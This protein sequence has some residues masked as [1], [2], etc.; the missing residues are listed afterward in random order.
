M[1]WQWN[2][3]LN[4]KQLIIIMIINNDYMPWGAESKDKNI[5]RSYT[6]YSDISNQITIKATMLLLLLF[7]SGTSWSSRTR[8]AIIPAAPVAIVAS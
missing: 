7:T 4:I 1:P 2:V 6:C 5:I 8:I 3:T